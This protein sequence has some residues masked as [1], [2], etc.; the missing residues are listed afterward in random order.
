M[1]KEERMTPFDLHASAAVGVVVVLLLIV[2][3]IEREVLRALGG[4]R[5]AARV[6]ALTGASVPLLV[7]AAAVMAARLTHILH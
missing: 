5:A 7:A 3:L 1:A 6:R 2:V 4:D